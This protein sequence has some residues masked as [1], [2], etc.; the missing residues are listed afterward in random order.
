MMQSVAQISWG[1]CTCINGS[2]NHP[3]IWIAPLK[4]NPIYHLFTVITKHSRKLDNKL[5]LL[6]FIYCNSQ[7]NKLGNYVN[8]TIFR[9]QNLKNYY[10]NH[11]TNRE[12][13][14]KKTF[15]TT[16]KQLSQDSHTLLYFNWNEWN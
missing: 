3:G 2:H 12:R 5:R 6:L 7:N 4:K 9:D 8:E 16:V 11:I 13:K 15:H 10:A 1:F 14:Q